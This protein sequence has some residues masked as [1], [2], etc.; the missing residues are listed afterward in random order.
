MLRADVDISADE[1][2]SP[3]DMSNKRHGESCLS[4]EQLL[5]QTLNILRDCEDSE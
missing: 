4:L 2:S 1:L 3:G 5:V